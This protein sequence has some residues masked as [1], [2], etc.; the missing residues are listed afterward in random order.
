MKKHLNPVKKSIFTEYMNFLI[1]NQLKIKDNNNNFNQNNNIINI[2]FNSLLDSTD[3]N[4]YE[5]K[6]I[7]YD[8]GKTK[9]SSFSKDSFL[10]FD[11]IN[12]KRNY[13]ENI[14]FTENKNNKAKDTEVKEK[15]QK[16]IEKFWN[17]Y[18]NK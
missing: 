9:G 15:T 14:N 3:K 2:Q 16:K 4:D 1:N 17:E 12:N 10:L 7:N 8:L 6:F 13:L 11:K 18:F 5:S